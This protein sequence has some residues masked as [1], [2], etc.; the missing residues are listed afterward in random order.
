VSC[1]SATACTAVGTYWIYIS[2]VTRYTLA[3]VWNGKKWR[4][5]PTPPHPY[6]SDDFLIEVSC[7]SAAVCKAVGGNFNAAGT[8][9]L[10]AEGQ[11]GERWETE[12]IPK[13]AGG[14]QLFGVSCTSAT[15]CTAVG[16]G[17]NHALA[18]TWNGKTW[19]VEP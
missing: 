3:E 4:I 15:A 10:L 9:P 2:R 11:N 1:T 19:K 14:G 13:P 6:G 5:D 16:V 12:A 7:T 8:K 17:V 18:Y